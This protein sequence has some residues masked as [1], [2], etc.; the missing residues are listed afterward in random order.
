MSPAQKTDFDDARAALLEGKG[1]S[2]T[3]INELVDNENAQAMKDLSDIAGIMQKGM[4]NYLAE[5]MPDI[6]AK[7]NYYKF[8]A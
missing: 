1:E 7:N 5:N 6:M 2:P 4:G 8:I 3:N